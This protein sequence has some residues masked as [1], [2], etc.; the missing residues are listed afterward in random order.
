VLLNAVRR[1]LFQGRAMP[2]DKATPKTKAALSQNGYGKRS[3]KTTVGM[4]ADTLGA[5]HTFDRI[6]GRPQNHVSQT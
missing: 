2:K 1:K 3:L 6:P 5:T 4:S